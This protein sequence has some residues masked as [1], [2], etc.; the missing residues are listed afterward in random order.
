MKTQA[1]RSFS[2]DDDNMLVMIVEG[3]Y[4]SYKHRCSRETYNSVVE[5][6]DDFRKHSI[7]E[8]ANDLDLP[9][10]QTAVAVA[11][12]KEKSLLEV[13]NRRNKAT[14]QEIYEHA[15]EEWEYL[16]FQNK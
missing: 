13:N 3:K 15:Q 9:W 7:E 16:S 12:L 14:K 4:T 10:T 1:P 2:I 11:F 6:F 5:A 8:I